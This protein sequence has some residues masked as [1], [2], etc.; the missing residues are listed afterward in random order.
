MKHVDFQRLIDEV[1]RQWSRAE[2]SLRTLERL[3][4]LGEGNTSTGIAPDIV[5]E[6]AYFRD[7]ILNLAIATDELLMPYPQYFEKLVQGREQG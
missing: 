1:Q 6:V 5:R 7:A 3:G 4:P 2:P